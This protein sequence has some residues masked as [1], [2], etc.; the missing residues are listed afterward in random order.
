MTEKAGPATRLP[1]RHYT[2]A[3]TGRSRGP[4]PAEQ[5]HRIRT[6]FFYALSVAVL[7]L[8][9]SY[10]AVPLYRLY[11][12]V[13]GAGGKAEAATD[14]F[15]PENLVPRR[16]TRP[17]RITFNSDVSQSLNW[18]FKPQQKEVY[19]YPGETALVFYTARNNSDRDIVGISTYNV[20]PS[21][22]GAYFNKIQC[23]CFEE[24]MLRAGE[25]VDMPIFFF[26]DPDFREQPQ[27][28]DVDTI[29]L[30]YTFFNA[31]RC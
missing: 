3:P 10:A 4:P 5:Q 29:T 1:L 21:K 20:T 12:S 8:G 6:S 24:Q 27:M 7:L 18:S 2:P 14:K 22:A 9:L 31:K 13:M 30:S 23:F 16:D 17:I 15:Q 26:I 25:Q 28:R 11:C 19:V